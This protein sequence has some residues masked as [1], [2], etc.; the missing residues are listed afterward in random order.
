MKDFDKMLDPPDCEEDQKKHLVPWLDE[1]I[2]VYEAY[3]ELDR[4]KDK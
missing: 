2:E 4:V 3:N 1:L